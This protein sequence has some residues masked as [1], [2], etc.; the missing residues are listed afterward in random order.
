MIELK[1]INILYGNAESM[2]STNGFTSRTF[3]LQR[4]VRQGCPIAPYIYILQAEPFA[5]NIRKNPDIEGIKLPGGLEA[6]LNMFA[7]DSQSLISKEKSI[8]ALFQIL[9]KYELA[10]GASV[11]YHKTKGLLLGTWRTKPPPTN[12]IQ[13]VNQIKALGVI[14]GYNI[15]DDEIWQSKLL[16]I[17]NKLKAWRRR[18]LTYDGKVL[19]IK[20]LGISV[21]NYEIQM[22]GI[23]EKYVKLLK[24]KLWSFLWDTKPGLIHKEAASLPKSKGGLGMLDVENCIK[25]KQIRLINE[26]NESEPQ[27]W[28]ALAKYWLSN[29]DPGITGNSKITLFSDLRKLKLNIMPPF[30]KNAI[31]TWSSLLQHRKITS[32]REIL[33]ESL[34]CNNLILC[35]KYPIYFKHWLNDNI[36]K[37]QDIWNNE[38]NSWKSEHEILKQ[39]NNQNSW[40]TDYLA[41]RQAI[42]ANWIKI[43]KDYTVTQKASNLTISD[44]DNILIN[45]KSISKCTNKEILGILQEKYSQPKCI[46]YWNKKTGKDQQWDKIWETLQNNT[47]IN[48]VKQF[49]W[50]SLHNVINTKHRLRKMNKGDGKCPLCKIHQEDQQHL[51]EKCVK[52]QPVKNKLNEKIKEINRNIDLNWEIIMFGHCEGLNK[53]E[54]SAMAKIIY[55]YKWEIWKNRN[56]KIFENKYDNFNITWKKILN[57]KPTVDYSL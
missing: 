34:F 2:I 8:E 21:A 41:L 13:F 49:Q 47:C 42:P 37:V 48:K 38:I 26:I 32:R 22:R 6:K 14:H 35:K 40:M 33:N 1:W 12:K 9:A 24:E 55:I 28:N 19:L 45:N 11:N 52:I 29:F 10:S 27:Q 50:K 20:A 46:N 3:K 51:F 57:H 16:K 56:Q 17:E 4:S 39:L 36:S 25:I 30:Y 53:V 54:S 18:T 5:T 43:L 23:P 15:N 7:D 44:T 31:G